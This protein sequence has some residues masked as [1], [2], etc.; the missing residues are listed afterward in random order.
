[1]DNSTQLFDYVIDRDSNKKKGIIEIQKKK[2][3]KQINFDLLDVRCIQFSSEVLQNCFSCVKFM[4]RFKLYY[5][6]K[7]TTKKKNRK[8]LQISRNQT[9]L[10]SIEQQI[11]M[12]IVKCAHQ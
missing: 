5:R 12:L 9:F 4:Q 10:P 3:E 7:K 1:M 2:T 8:C 6:T 11:A